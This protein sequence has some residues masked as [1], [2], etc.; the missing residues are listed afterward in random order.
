[1]DVEPASALEPDL[2]IFDARTMDAHL[3]QFN[4]LIRW[5]TM[6]N[7]GIGVFGL[8]LAAIGLAGVTTH[9]VARRRKE[10]GLRIALGARSSQYA[11]SLSNKKLDVLDLEGGILAWSHENGPLVKVLN[12]GKTEPTKEIHVYDESWN[13][14]HPDY[15]AVW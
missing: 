15:K 13:F 4:G 9:S 3:D 12:K 11:N 8:V 14:A 6:V 7:G 5:T 2:T 10:I 1:M